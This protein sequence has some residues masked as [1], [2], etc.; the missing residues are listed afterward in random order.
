ML[1][2]YTWPH[3]DYRKPPE[4]G[5]SAPRRLPLVEERHRPRLLL[6]PLPPHPPLLSRLHPLPQGER[7]RIG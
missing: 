4:L 2:T 7:G 5:A 1:K 3:Y 6:P